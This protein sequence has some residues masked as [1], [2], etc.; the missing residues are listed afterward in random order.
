MG[1]TKIE[2]NR[3][4]FIPPF[5][6]DLTAWSEGRITTLLVA[7]GQYANSLFRKWIKDTIK[8]VD[9]LLEKLHSKHGVL[10]SALMNL[11]GNQW[12]YSF[13]NY[14]PFISYA[15]AN[16]YRVKY[17]V[18][19]LIPVS[20]E[21]SQYDV[22]QRIRIKQVRNSDLKQFKKTL[23]LLSVY[24][25]LGNLGNSLNNRVP[26]HSIKTIQEYLP[27]LD[28]WQEFI[29]FLEHPNSFTSYKGIPKDLSIHLCAEDLQDFFVELTGR[30]L[31]GIIGPLLS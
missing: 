4:T 17:R 7:N 27:D 25:E 31:S 18:P 28:K 24:R 29:S 19:I 5:R 16:K 9:S 20:L 15:L 12:L 1:R 8:S 14:T 23:Y 21:P 10:P 30:N 2:I 22:E 11:L 13:G 6:Q 3:Q 26:F